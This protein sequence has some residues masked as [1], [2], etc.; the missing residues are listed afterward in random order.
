MEE[1]RDVEEKKEGALTGA[2][3]IKRTSWYFRKGRWIGI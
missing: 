3:E 2:E 1:R